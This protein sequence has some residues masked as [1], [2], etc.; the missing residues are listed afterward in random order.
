MLE[1]TLG[2]LKNCWFLRRPYR[3]AQAHVLR[4][5][6]RSKHYSALYYSLFSRAFRREMHAVLHG[7]RVHQLQSQS[8]RTGE[9]L[10]RRNIHRLEKGL[11]MRP[12]RKV[13]ALDYIEE[14]VKC[15]K[16]EIK[17]VGGKP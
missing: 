10:L 12:P 8:Q 15:F 2:R 13:F 16:Q 14:T 11:L 7:S 6:M 5:S 9:Y 4:R 3:A 17:R 1:R